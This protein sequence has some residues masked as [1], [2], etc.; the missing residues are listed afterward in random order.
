VFDDWQAKNVTSVLDE[1]R[2]GYA[3]NM[4]SLR[5]LAGKAT[6]LGVAI[7]EGVAVTGLRS[8][9]G[10]RAI[11]A[12]ET[13]A[14]TISCDE[15]VVAAGPWDSNHG[16]KMIGV[17]ELVASELL[18]EPRG[19]LEP[20]RFSRYESGKLHPVSKSPFPWS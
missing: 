19:L 20:F 12:V 2:G 4:A 18:G 15:V 3:N 11:S 6:A 9:N 13:T 5:V 7:I 8:D 10:A 1:K 17:G 16:Y 14:G